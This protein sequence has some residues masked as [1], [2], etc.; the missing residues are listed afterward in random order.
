VP[1]LRPA[2]LS[3]DTA[4]TLDVALHALD[5][6]ESEQA[7]PDGVLLLQPTSPF[8][9]AE[10]MRRGVSAFAEAPSHAVVGFSPAPVHPAWC[11]RFSTAGELEPFLGA[12]YLGQRSQDLPPAYTVNGAFYL[13]SPSE[14]RRSRS[15]FPAG[16][17]S[18]IME[19]EAEAVDIDT[20]ADWRSA[21]VWAGLWRQDSTG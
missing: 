15:F 19:N 9:S 10:A 3:D 6:F 16:L 8:R 7:S 21:E 1:W 18:L 4:T 14:L 13:I 11:F 17:R 2:E 12:E 20:E 5:W